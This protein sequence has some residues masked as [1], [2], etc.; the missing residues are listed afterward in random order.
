M[1]TVVLAADRGERLLNPY[2]RMIFGA[3]RFLR[4][5]RVRGELFPGS[6]RNLHL[7]WPEYLLHGRLA[8]RFAPACEAAYW[9]LLRAIDRVKRNGGQ[10][11]WTAHNLAPHGY[12]SP[13]A[14]AV[15]T[16]WSR[17]I[18]RR[19]DTVV[20]LSPSGAR[21]VREAVPEVA[22]ARFAIVAHPHYRDLYG[23]GGPGAARTR[24]GIPAGARLACAAGLIRGYKR[25][26]ELVAAF[27]ACA[28]DDEY[29]LVAGP[30]HEPALRAEVERAARLCPRVRLAI[31]ALA[32][33]D[34]AATIR[35]SDLF[36]ANFGALLNSG[37]VIAALSLDTPVLAPRLGALPDLQAQV[38]ERWLALF[39]G[40]LDRDRLR[41]ALDRVREPPGGRPDLAPND[42]DRVIDAHLGLYL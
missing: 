22:S 34:F 6:A 5:V 14:E 42:P 39:D 26:P 27:A 11:I 3:E 9:T 8:R 19:V 30:C 28:R 17:E 31:G 25:I 33:A 16:R 4:H 23:R 2:L 18:L 38:G 41:H 15:Y 1:K 35:A 32:D 21:A 10:V 12:P 37:S 7:H 20:A 36:V 13:H 29:L 40:A 24:H